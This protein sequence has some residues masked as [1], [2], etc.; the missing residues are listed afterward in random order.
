VKNIFESQGKRFD[1][2]KIRKAIEWLLGRG[3]SSNE[4]HQDLIYLSFVEDTVRPP[5][6]QAGVFY[7]LGIAGRFR[8]VRSVGAMELPT[9]TT[10]ITSSDRL[11]RPSLAERAQ[12]FQRARLARKCGAC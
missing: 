4:V 12:Q 5:D 1:E 2:R 9:D 10:G 3:F 6:E 8:H 7:V 11:I